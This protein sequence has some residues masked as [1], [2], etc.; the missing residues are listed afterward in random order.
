MLTNHVNSSVFHHPC[1]EFHDWGG[2]GGGGG[3]APARVNPY[4]IAI[5]TGGCGLADHVFGKGRQAAQLAVQAS[6]L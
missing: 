4:P 5:P 3:A 2:G 6:R 1:S